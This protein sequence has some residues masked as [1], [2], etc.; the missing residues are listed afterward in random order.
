MIFS[1]Y[2]VFNSR[3]NLSVLKEIA[4]KANFRKI[5]FKINLKMSVR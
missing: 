1:L 4:S 2:Y 5:A 3:E